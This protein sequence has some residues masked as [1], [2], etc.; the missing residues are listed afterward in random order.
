MTNKFRVSF[1]AVNTTLELTDADSRDSMTHLITE[2]SELDEFYLQLQEKIDR[3][4]F[5]AQVGRRMDRL[6]RF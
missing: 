1:T 4:D 5:N 2:G 3:E 6:L